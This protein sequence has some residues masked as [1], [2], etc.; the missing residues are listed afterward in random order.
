V[1]QEL[2]HI[3][4]FYFSLSKLDLNDLLQAL[5]QPQSE[6]DSTSREQEIYAKPVKS[7]REQSV[8]YLADTSLHPQ[9]QTNLRNFTPSLEKMSKLIVN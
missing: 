1:R 7:L 2:S 3:P 9:L 5:A 6:S 4:L 8:N